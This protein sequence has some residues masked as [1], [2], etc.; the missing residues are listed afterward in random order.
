MEPCKQHPLLFISKDK[1]EIKIAKSMCKVCPSFQPCLDNACSLM[2]NFGIWG[3]VNF[4][5]ISERKKAWF[6][7]NKRRKIDANISS[8][9]IV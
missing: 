3:G 9:P 5:N 2:E 1:E 7:W 4:D 6:A 8:L